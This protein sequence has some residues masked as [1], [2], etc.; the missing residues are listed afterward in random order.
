MVTDDDE[1]AALCRSL[2][3]QGRD[4]SG[5]WLAH[6]R[7]GYNYRIS[8]LT[9]ALGRSQLSRLPAILERR[10]EVAARYGA[11]LGT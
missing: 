6:V 9:A 8:E 7:L 10:R 1:I 5:A 11:L 4:D 3:N 2:V